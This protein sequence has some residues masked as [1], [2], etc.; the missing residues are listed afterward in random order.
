MS[1]QYGNRI[2][3]TRVGGGHLTDTRRVFVLGAK[4]F[5]RVPRMDVYRR[6][7]KF[8]PGFIDET[9]STMCLHMKTSQTPF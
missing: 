5:L 3:Y 2:M 9:K 8:S 6:M 1:R 7:S 4:P